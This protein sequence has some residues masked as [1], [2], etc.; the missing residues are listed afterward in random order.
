MHEQINL[1][2]FQIEEIEP[3]KAKADPKF[4]LTP[5]QW[6]LYRLIERNTEEG[7]KTTQNEI[8]A[9]IEGYEWNE[10]SANAHDHCVSIW[11]DINGAKGLNFSSEIQKTIISDN[12]EYWIGNKEEVEEYQK[13]LWR[14]LYPRLVRYWNIVS[15]AK[16]DGQGQLFSCHGDL[17]DDES[18]ARGYVKAFAKHEKL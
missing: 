12:F 18:A 1:F 8:C 10:K 5:R 9:L 2:D 11:T 13:K 15:K 14:D 16:M 7:R 6:A 4:R 3:V 17:I